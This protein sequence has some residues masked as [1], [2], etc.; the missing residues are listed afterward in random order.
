MQDKA[1]RDLSKVAAQKANDSPLAG[2][3]W[4]MYE[5]ELGRSVKTMRK[6]QLSYEEALSLFQQRYIMHVQR[7]NGN[8]LGKTATALG[9][10]RNTLARILLAVNETVAKAGIA[11]V[12]P[13]H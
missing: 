5:A 8:H 6:A 4:L 7:V 3:G 11:L 9:V 2:A 12:R 1:V 13:S 10:H